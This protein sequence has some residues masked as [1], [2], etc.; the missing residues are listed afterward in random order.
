M[1]KEDKITK[2]LVR[3]SVLFVTLALL[4]SFV[5]SLN[6]LDFIYLWLFI[7]L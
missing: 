7:C 6:I 5:V 1:S 2:A 4:G 3:Y